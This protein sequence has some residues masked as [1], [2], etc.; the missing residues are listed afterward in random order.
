MATGEDFQK[1]CRWLAE[2]TGWAVVF[3]ALAIVV[4]AV[5]VA[6]VKRLAGFGGGDFRATVHALGV[7][8]V[9]SLPAIFL[10]LALRSAEGVF[11]RMGKGVIMDAANAKGLASCGHG[12]IEAA[13]ASLVITPTV[14]G[15]L[16]GE[17]SLD[18]DFEWTYV[19]LL[20]LGT[21][22]TLFA[23]VL[24]DAAAARAEL[25]AII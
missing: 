25:D 11:D 12:V 22:L 4:D 7:E 2:M 6:G 18:V 19:V 10:V 24:R 3:L 15:F 23:D 9:S 1:R 14:L 21:A 13:I 20:L 16:R 17:R 5:W 8:I